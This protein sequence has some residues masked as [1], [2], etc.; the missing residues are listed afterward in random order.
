MYMCIY[1]CI[2]IYIYIYEPMYVKRQRTVSLAFE[3]V[4]LSV[5]NNNNRDLSAVVYQSLHL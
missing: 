3:S 5:Y 4:N 2:Y 1:M